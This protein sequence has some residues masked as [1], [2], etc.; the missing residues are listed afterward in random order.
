MCRVRRGVPLESSR[1]FAGARRDAQHTEL[2]WRALPPGGVVALRVA[3][4]PPVA[5]ALAAL[6]RALPALPADLAP[7]LADLDLGDFNA[8]LYRCDAEERDAGGGGVYDVPGYGPLVYAGLQGVA[9]LLAVVRPADDLGHPLCDNLRAG[10]WLPEYLWRRLEREP[11]LAAVGARVRAALAPL[12]DLP[13]YLRPAYFEATVSALHAAASRAALSRCAAWCAEGPLA[14][15]LALTSVQLAGAVPSAPLPLPPPTGRTLSL[16]AGLPHFATGYMRCWGRD[17][18][19]ALRGMFLLTG[20]YEDARAHILGFA[21]CLRHGL[22][23]N[24]LDAGVRARFNCRDAVWW[25]LYAIKQVG[26]IPTCKICKSISVRLRR[27]NR[28]IVR[29]S[30]ARRRRAGRRC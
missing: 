8:L 16:S 7:A 10:D 3:P 17:T 20:R 6:R 14:R 22:I 5:A 24:L 9:S 29:C 11:R 28:K 21:A 12:A 13:R 15:A 1:V 19:V 27:L 25:W 23:P 18:F 4:H 2:A 30:T 26:T